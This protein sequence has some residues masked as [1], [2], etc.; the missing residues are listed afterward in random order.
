MNNK[1]YFL[2]KWFNRHSIVVN[3]IIFSILIVTGITQFMV[4]KNTILKLFGIYTFIILFTLFRIRLSH[5]T[6]DMREFNIPTEGEAVIITKDFYYD[7]T[8]RKYINTSD[9]SRK[10][11]TRCI[12]KGEEWVIDSVSTL[13]GDDCIITIKDQYGETI[14]LEYIETRKHWETKSDFRNNRLKELGI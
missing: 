13:L 14:R 9:T 3:I 7:G 1:L 6:I 12:K 11:N 2:G 8:F 4:D 5:I 10:P